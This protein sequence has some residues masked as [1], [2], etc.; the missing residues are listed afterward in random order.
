MNR[1]DFLGA[2][3]AASLEGSAAASRLNIVL[4]HCHD[5]GW[6]LGC[7]G[8][9]SVSSPNLDRFASQGALF[10]RSFCTAPQCSPSR[11]SIFT[12]R[13]PHTNGVMGLTHANFGWDL[14]SGERH[15]GQI[16]KEAGYATAGVGIIHE[17]HSGAA[18]CG[19]DDY[20]PGARAQQMADAAI[21]RLGQLARG[22]KP[23]YL[24][25]GCIEPHRL[26][27]PDDTEYMGFLGPDL[28]ADTSRGVWI[29][30]YLRDTTGT[31]A[32]LAELQGAVRHMDAQ[33]GRV[34]SSL[35]ELGLESNTLAIFTTDHGIAMPRAKCSVYEPGLQTAFMLRLP[36]RQGWSGGVRNKAMISNIDYLPT[37]LEAAGVPV[38]AGVQGRSFAP[39]LDGRSYMPRD[40]IFGELTH[41]D[42]YDPRRSVRT[43]THKLI[44]NFSSAPAF[45][46]PSQSWRPRSD[47]VVPASHAVS[48]HPPYELYD[49]SRDPWEQRDVAGDAAYASVLGDLRARL[50]KHMEATGDPLLNGA[51]SPPL[52]NRSVD[53][54]R[55]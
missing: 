3:A 48:Y 41:H 54:L 14:N 31:R 53:W 35:A 36:G 13:Y 18:R 37:I 20:T 6:H 22:D 43:E 19:L 30:P 5:L 49:L 28:K 23:F 25:A 33:M 39:L 42:Y 29:P 17:T 4:L 46:D 34:L 38:P 32:E 12:G 21:A 51:V 52:H 45:M 44:V 10:E 27:R 15:L 8:V 24:Q 1:R 9:E 26:G 11:A 47:T 2:A 50:R 40:A 55:S 7:Y 16:L